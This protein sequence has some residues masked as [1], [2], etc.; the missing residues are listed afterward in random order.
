MNP[1]IMGRNWVHLRDGENNY[2]LTVTT[3]ELV[4]VGSYE[5]FIGDITLNKDF[6]SGYKFSIIMENAILK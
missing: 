2:D 5:T 4:N 6:G 1:N 3:N